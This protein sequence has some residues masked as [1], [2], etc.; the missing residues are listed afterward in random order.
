MGRSKAVLAVVVCAALSGCGG[1]ADAAPTDASRD[2]FCASMRWFVSEGLD[3]L[4]GGQFP[5]PE[6][7]LAELARDWS[8]HLVEV[9][10]PENMSDD[11]REGFE[12]FVGRIDDI[13]GGDMSEF[14]WDGANAEGDAEKAFSNFVSNT[15]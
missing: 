8:E 12:K 6:D 15:C 7:D 10:T 4:A 11:A 2:D 1:A 13:D 9:G 14:G 3:R 5:P